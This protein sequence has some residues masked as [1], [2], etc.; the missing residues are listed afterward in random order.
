M[1][2]Y[3]PVALNSRT[4]HYE[5]SDV[6]RSGASVADA[7]VWLTQWRVRQAMCCTTAFQEFTAAVHALK[8]INLKDKRAI[9]NDE[10]LS[11]WINL[12]NLLSLHAAILLP[13]PD[14]SDRAGRVQWMKQA[15]YRVGTATISLL[16]LEHGILRSKLA[17]LE[18]PSV[19]YS[20]VVTHCNS[21]PQRSDT[22]N[23]RLYSPISLFIH[24]V[25]WF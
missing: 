15:K 19:P 10:K 13:W 2:K 14:S 17:S 12:Y 6:G 11:F 9:S 24:N 25:N 8:N 4:K 16:Q 20:E 23:F 22:M 18:L 3:P 21:F 7:G 1:T 5:T